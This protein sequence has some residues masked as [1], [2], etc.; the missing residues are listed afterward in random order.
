MAHGFGCQPVTMAA[1]VQFQASHYILFPNYV[2]IFNHLFR[3]SDSMKYFYLNL[4]MFHVLG[5]HT[6]A[7]AVKACRMLKRQLGCISISQ[8]M[9]IN[10]NGVTYVVLY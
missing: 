5:I 10:N 7:Q 8:F 1:Q 4:Y 3:E 9:H 2:N 6:G